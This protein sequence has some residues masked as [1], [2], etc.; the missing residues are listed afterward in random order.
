[1]VLSRDRLI[2][3]LWAGAAMAFGTTLCGV[4]P[5]MGYAQLVDEN[6]D[7]E[8][9]QILF[10][11]D[12]VVREFEDGPS[13]AEGDVRA[14]FGERYLRAD[15][16]IYNPTTDV[17]EAEGNVSITDENLQTSFAGR[18]ELSGDL[19]DGIA[20]NFSALLENNARL[21]ADNA[22]R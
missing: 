21:A 20:E 16:L 2:A 3:R 10:E 4:Y 5:S 18:V 19:R 17:V 9:D 7:D 8:T 15:R 6:E 12:N 22:V 13:V 11:A 1:M 14:F